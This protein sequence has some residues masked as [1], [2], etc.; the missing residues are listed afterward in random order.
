MSRVM[1]DSSTSPGRCFTN[2]NQPL[3]V[4]RDDTVGR[5]TA[6]Q[7]CPGLQACGFE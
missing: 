7:M 4:E 6:Q 3:F 1:V 2:A 5:T